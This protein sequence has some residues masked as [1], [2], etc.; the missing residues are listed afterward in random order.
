M[1]FLCSNFRQINDNVVTVKNDVART[2]TVSDMQFVFKYFSRFE[3]GYNAP[4]PLAEETINT[5]DQV[6]NVNCSET[7]NLDNITNEVPPQDI[8]DA[9]KHENVFPL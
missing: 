1:D 8:N 2:T 9:K 3:R 5:S 4:E 6:V 7:S